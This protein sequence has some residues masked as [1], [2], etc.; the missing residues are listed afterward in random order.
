MQFTQIWVDP[1][2]PD[3]WRK[4]LNLKRWIIQTGRPTIFRRGNL[5]AITL[6]PPNANTERRWIEKEVML[7]RPEENMWA[8]EKEM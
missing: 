5:S 1:K 3:E 2:A 7:R 8:I 4:D 6:I